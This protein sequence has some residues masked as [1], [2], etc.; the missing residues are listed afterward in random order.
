MPSMI[1]IDKGISKEYIKHI[2]LKG[3]EELN[4]FTTL[5]RSIWELV[6]ELDILGHNNIVNADINVPSGMEIL[7]AAEYIPNAWSPSNKEIKIWSATE[8]DNTII[9]PIPLYFRKCLEFSP[10]ISYDKI[11]LLDL[12]FL[13]I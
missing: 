11:F 5:L 9:D 3:T 4:T 8:V 1:G 10:F 2:Q 13:T 7:R 6:I 12:S